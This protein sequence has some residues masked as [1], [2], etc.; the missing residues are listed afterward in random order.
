MPSN[1]SSIKTVSNKPPTRLTWSEN[2]GKRIRTGSWQELAVAT[3]TCIR[4]EL[5]AERWENA[6]Q[7]V[8]YFMEEAKVCH[9]V[10]QSWTNGFVEWLRKQGVSDEE[11]SAEWDRLTQLLELPDGTVFEPQVLWLELGS[12]AGRLSAGIRVVCFD[13]DEAEEGVEQL[14]EQWRQMHDRWV[15]L[16]WGLLTYIANRFGEDAI[17]DC[18]REVLTPYL[19]ERYRPFDI[20]ERPYEDTL[21]LNLYIALEAM[22]GHL[23]GPG[24]LGNIG[25]V[26]HDDR[27]VLSFSPCGSCGRG[28]IGCT[29]EKTP[30]RCEAPYNFGITT[31]KHDWAWNEIGVSYYEAHLSFATDM[32]PIEQWGAPV[33]V[34]DPPLYPDECTGPNPKPCMWTIYKTVAAVPEEAYRRVGKTKPGVVAD[35]HG[36][37]DA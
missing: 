9:N 5:S 28:K 13:H 22:H 19:N 33:R 20:R 16:Q 2:V 4:T 21:D 30:S 12:S 15:D 25:L 32:W 3:V 31:K 1:D 18:Y 8:D 24:R 35:S 37:S 7:L 26:E 23:C 17:G 14:R 34:T 27:W 36:T 11:F 6:A 29:D 10:Y